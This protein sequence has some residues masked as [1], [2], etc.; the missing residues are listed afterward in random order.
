[1]ASPTP[2][3]SPSAS[4]NPAD[5]VA[6]LQALAAN[7]GGSA[8]TSQDATVLW[9]DPYADEPRLRREMMITPSQAVAK[10]TQ[11]TPDQQ[12]A[13]G[14]SLYRAG[15]INDPND[16]AQVQQKWSDAVKMADNSSSIGKNLS[17][18]DA[19]NMMMTYSTGSNGGVLKPKQTTTTNVVIP[20]PADAKVLINGVFQS[21]LGRDPT[22]QELAKY[23]A[24]VTGAAQKNPSK[25]TTTYT[26]DSNGQAIGRNDVTSGGTNLQQVAL[27]MAKS[28]PQYGAYQAAT[29]Y[30]NALLGA[31]GAV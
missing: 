21:A 6:Q 15:V 29:T 8:T 12:R 23:T 10:F 27:D 5:I 18:W 20:N 22:D 28:D 2:S 7:G 14:A 25:T 9:S 13:L 17:P 26:Y 19:L 31:I 30:F 11:L 3:P 24:L 1:M 4:G 16:F